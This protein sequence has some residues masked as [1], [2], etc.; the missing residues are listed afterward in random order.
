MS[1]TPLSPDEIAALRSESHEY[2]KVATVMA[3]PAFEAGVLPTL[4][5]RH[6]Y[7]A[8]DYIAG[9]GQAGEYWPV[10]RAIFDA[11]YVLATLDAARST[12]E[13]NIGRLDRAMAR[14]GVHIDL[15]RKPRPEG[16]KSCAGPLAAIAR[17]YATLAETDHPPYPLPE[18]FEKMT[19]AE[20][21][22]YA[23]RIGFADRLCA[24]LAEQEPRP[25]G[26]P[27]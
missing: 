6:S 11:T 9:P 10:K 22:G 13:L 8:G 2:R 27:Q 20:F 16:C 5:G 14:S 24:A 15:Q 3:A 23:E 1:E 12:D 17:E 25:E 7:E 19:E 18:D 26:E 21:W 4:E